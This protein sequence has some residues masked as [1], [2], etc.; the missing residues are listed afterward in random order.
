MKFDFDRPIERRNTASLKWDIYKDRDIIPMWVAD[1]DF[2]SPP[3]VLE[4]LKQRVDHGVFGYTL[5]PQALVEV[6]V[7][8]LQ[9]L[10]NWQ[11][12][13]DWIVWLPGLVT[14][15]NVM[16]R[17]VG[18]PG[19]EVLVNTPIYPPFL[20]APILSGRRRVL[21][22]MVLEG[23]RWH[24]D[25]DDIKA[26]VSDK[27]SVYLLCN[28]HNPCGRMLSKEE[29]L[30]VAEVMEASDTII[31]SDE[32]HCDLLLDKEKKHIPIASLDKEISRRTVTLMAPSKT[33]NIAGLGCSFAVIEEESLRKKFQRAMMGIVPHVNTLGYTAALAA[34]RFGDHWLEEL[35]AYLRPNAETVYNRI[36]AIDGLSTAPVEATYLA[37]IDARES[38]LRDPHRF[39]EE[40]GVGLSNGKEFGAPGF[41]RLNFGC[42][43]ALLETAIERMQSAMN[44]RNQ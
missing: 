3:Q 16:C 11:I 12:D 34:Y 20:S 28:P 30:K 42:R 9:R 25:I 33:W 32:I 36:N 4:V 17:A 26:K 14:G 1:M 41:V 37:W 35:L 23:E 39:F 44:T 8:R 6:V 15:L 10:Y 24:L 7:E 31:C 18:S 19:D 29:L 13:P 2:Q 43:K 40:A 21:S 5:A 27:T 38:G 22:P